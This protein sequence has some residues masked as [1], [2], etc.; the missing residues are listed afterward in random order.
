MKTT[1]TRLS[2]LA[3]GLLAVLPAVAQ[4]GI[5]RNAAAPAV[6]AMLDVNVASLATKLGM[7]IPRMTD[8]QRIAIAPNATAE[9][10]LVYQT[11]APAGFWYWDGAVWLPFTAGDAWGL[12][13]NTGTLPGTDYVG[14]F[15][16]TNFRMRTN[17]AIAV[18]P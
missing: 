2:L 5:S 1:S 15:D 3:T 12:F 11:N 9:G 18:P 13:G 4:V 17:G 8:A 16:N 14:T 6:D 7:L 10:L